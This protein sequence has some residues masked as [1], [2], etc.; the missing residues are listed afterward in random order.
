[1]IKERHSQGNLHLKTLLTTFIENLQEL[2]VNRGTS[3]SFHDPEFKQNVIP[4]YL[5]H[6]DEGTCLHEKLIYC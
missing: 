3:G 2:I 5:A 4:S 6:V 1:M